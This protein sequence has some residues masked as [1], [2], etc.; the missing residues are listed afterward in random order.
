MISAEF[1]DY[2][3]VEHDQIFVSSFRF[4]PHQDVDM[5]FAVLRTYQGPL[6]KSLSPAQAE[7]VYLERCKELEF[8]GFDM[9][10]VEGKDGN[11]YRLGLTPHGMLVFDGQ[12]KIGQFLWQKIQS[13]LKASEQRVISW[14]F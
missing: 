11:T 2:N 9:H 6:R 3:P 1:G 13:S 12:L 7:I 8:Y 4:H 14:R 10:T 5:E